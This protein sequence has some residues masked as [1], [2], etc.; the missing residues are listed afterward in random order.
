MDRRME[1]QEHAK[2]VKETM[3]GRGYRHFKGGLYL[4]LN[5]AVHSETSELLVVYTGW[6]DSKRRAQTWVRPLNMFLSDVDHEKYP[7]VKQV[8][9]FEL[10]R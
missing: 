7:D 9:R 1:A 2:K 3:V 4:V 6:G 5:I 8:K 10:I